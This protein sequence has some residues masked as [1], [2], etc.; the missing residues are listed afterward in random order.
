MDAITALTTR[1]SCPRL[2]APGPSA[3]QL[4]VLLSA[5]I[6]APD[7]GVLRPWRFIVLQGDERHALGNIMVAELL[8]KQPEADQK[9]QDSAFAKALRA[10]TM[11]VAIAETVENHKVPIWEQVLAVGAAVQNMMLAAHAMGLGA[12][13]R[14]GDLA[15]SAEAKA[16]LGFAE[17]DQVVAFLYLGT[18]AGPARSIPAETASSFLRQIP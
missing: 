13:W 10:P 8:R 1:T 16:A 11:V 5:A 17:K 9:A 7:H 2:D 4:E 18:P 14:T 3:E 12:M 15:N 6:R